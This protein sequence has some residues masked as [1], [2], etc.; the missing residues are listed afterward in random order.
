MAMDAKDIAKKVNSKKG[1]QAGS[2]NADQLRSTFGLSGND[3]SAPKDSSTGGKDNDL[4]G[5]NYLS[6]GDVKRLL[7]DKKLK[8]AFIASGG[9]ADSWSSSNDVDTAIDYLTSGKKTES[10]PKT[11]QQSETLSKAKAGVKAYEDNIMT[12]MGDYIVGRNG[13]TDPNKDFLKDYKLELGKQLKPKN[14]DGT[15]RHSQIQ[16]EKDAV[17]GNKQ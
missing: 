6:D 2:M 16:D 4:L 10:K 14:A 5:S 3:H 15:P 12:H 7:G 8:Q 11:Y 13:R 17:E 1:Y 9:S